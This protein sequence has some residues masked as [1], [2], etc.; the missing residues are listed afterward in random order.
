MT[1][2]QDKAFQAVLKA[3]TEALKTGLTESQIFEKLGW[4]SLP[5]WRPGAVLEPSDA[6]PR[7]YGWSLFTSKRKK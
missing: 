3:V 5:G 6:A 4:K 7:R 2:D 1:P